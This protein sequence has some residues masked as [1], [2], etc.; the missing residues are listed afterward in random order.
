MRR[1]KVSMARSQRLIKKWCLEIRSRCEDRFRRCYGRE[2]KRFRKE[3]KLKVD[4]VET[5]KIGI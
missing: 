2:S 1:T 3:G 5:T 4:F